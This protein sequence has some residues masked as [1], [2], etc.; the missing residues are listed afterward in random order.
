MHNAL[1]QALEGKSPQICF[2]NLYAAIYV[3]AKQMIG[4]GFPVDVM[5]AKLNGIQEEMVKGLS[6]G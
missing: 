5:V 1:L 2:D 3:V 4:E 6:N